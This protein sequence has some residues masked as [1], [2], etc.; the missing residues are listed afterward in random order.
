MNILNEIVLNKQSE[1]DHSFN[2]KK[3]RMNTV[4]L[5]LRKKPFFV[6]G[7]IKPKSP[8]AGV[9]REYINPQKV[10]QE[11]ESIGCAGISV[12]TDK[13][14]FGG[15]TQLFS[16]VREV[17]MLPLLR[18]DFIVHSTQISQTAEM[19]ADLILFIVRIL[20]PDQLEFFVHQSLD[21]FLIPL[22]EV[23]T[24]DEL[25]IA[26][27]VI[28]KMNCQSRVILA[29]NNRNLDTFETSLQVSVS[30]RQ[31]IP[32]DILSMS[33]SGIRTQPDLELL[34]NAGFNGVLIGEGLVSTSN[35]VL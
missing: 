27:K 11:F 26:V 16:Q 2:H 28:K 14:Y 6:F 20:S 34:Q 17:T 21:Y 29:V 8:S 12:L 7:E 4:L 25:I 15:S 24:E 35:L 13:K 18:K 22:I 32:S 5:D 30:L 10:T 23:N 33:L 31:Q 19:N 1:V 9:L 3:L